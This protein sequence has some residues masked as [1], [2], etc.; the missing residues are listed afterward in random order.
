MSKTILVFWGQALI[1]NFIKIRV[2]W[3]ENEGR[4]LLPN[5]PSI[6]W[7]WTHVYL[8]TLEIM[9]LKGCVEAETAAHRISSINN[10]WTNKT[11]NAWSVWQ[12]SVFIIDYPV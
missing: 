4:S 2:D 1:F 3:I 12:I 5:I 7:K 9:A 10:C 6:K 11:I 8:Y